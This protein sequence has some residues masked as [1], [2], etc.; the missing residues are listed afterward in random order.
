MR[1]R[2]RWQVAASG[3]LA[4]GQLLAAQPR[5]PPHSLVAMRRQE[6]WLDR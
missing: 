4:S 2:S 5:A 1:L 6:L 3:A